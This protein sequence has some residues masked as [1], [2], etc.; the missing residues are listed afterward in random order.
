[1]KKFISLLSLALILAST[2]AIADQQTVDALEANGIV[3]TTEQADA[4]SSAQGDDAFVIAVA[5]LVA[6][7]SSDRLAV[8]N[9]IQ[10]AVGIRPDLVIGITIYALAA[11]PAND[12]TDI[13]TG[14]LL[15][16]QNSTTVQ[17]NNLADQALECS[18]VYAMMSVPGDGDRPLSSNNNEQAASGKQ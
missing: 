6:D 14:A 9:I 4:I 12:N 15:G 7:N 13:C 10:T 8:K 11:T 2:T 5:A 16:I 3:L 1:M 18:T 17:P